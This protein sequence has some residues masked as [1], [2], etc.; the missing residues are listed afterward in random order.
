M[1]I[2]V[3]C[4]CGKSFKAKPELAGK[5]VKCPACGSVLQ[6]P[7][8]TPKP[9][10]DDPLGL[11]SLGDEIVTATPVGNAPTAGGY[12]QN[13]GYASAAPVRRAP[14][15]SG[16]NPGVKLA[17]IIGGIGVGGVLVI[18][19][20][21]ALLLPAVQAARQAA[22]RQAGL[23]G[24]G[25][26]SGGDW[27]EYKSAAGGYSVLMPR[28]P[29]T[30]SQNTPTA[31][32]MITANIALVDMK[33]QGAYFVT[34]S[35]VPMANFTQRDPNILL[36]GGI[37]GALQNIGGKIRTKRDIT[38]FGYPG[39]DIQF[40]G[41]TRGRQITGRTQF[42]LADDV[43]YQV[44]WLGFP[45][46]KPEGDLQRFF[47]SFKISKKASAP[48]P[49]VAAQP[50]VTQ[51]PVTQPPNAK[52]ATPKPTIPTPPVAQPNVSPPQNAV[53]KPPS[54]D[55]SEL[56]EDRR[57][58]IYRDIVNREKSVSAFLTQADKAEQR[59]SIDTANRMR[60]SAERMR[61]SH[62]R[63]LTMMHRI[64]QQQLDAIRS[65]GEAN[66]W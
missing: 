9:V 61:Q 21:V 32:G 37:N 52:P 6:I 17:L 26:S 44:M 33:D 5:R 49:K 3:S 40:D 29:Q 59:G 7:N 31:A 35:N 50:P 58:R 66:G 46:K 13:T 16:M 56:T 30:R 27:T 24:D 25:A 8:A 48:T 62:H 28:M 2:P 63:G 11:G 14:T 60:E 15:N 47:D 18:I 10:D 12:L 65:E 22:R 45:N 42:V 20:L 55:P 51:P 1:T 38:L 34:H 53:S 57:K 23:T 19:V 43:L 39:K 54:A 4:Q 41:N 64:S 36:E